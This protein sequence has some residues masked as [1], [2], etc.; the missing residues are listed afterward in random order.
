[1]IYPL[2][3]LR[4][5]E[6]CKHYIEGISCKAYPWRI[7]HSISKGKNDHSK[8]FGEHIETYWDEDYHYPSDNGIFYEKASDDLILKRK[9]AMEEKNKKLEEEEKN[10]KPKFDNSDDFDLYFKNTEKLYHYLKNNKTENN[11]QK[12]EKAIEILSFTQKNGIMFYPTNE[13]IEF[14]IKTE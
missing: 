10:R 2:I 12:K 9:I 7:P 3:G 5:C 1:M 11:E 8:P 14:W 6:T 4:R 13:E